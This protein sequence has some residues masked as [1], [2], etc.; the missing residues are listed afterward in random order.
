MSERYDIAI[1]G[2]GVVG[3]ALALL[4]VK[5]AGIAAASVLLIER[6][7]PRA[8]G[9]GAAFD[10]RVSAISP[11]NQA[12]LE[13]VGAW[14]RLD[15]ARIAAYE[16]MV[17]WHEAIPADSPDALIFDAA[18]MGEARLGV[19][20]ENRALQAALF[21]TCEAMGIVTR[22]DE[23]AA[24]QFDVDGVTLELGKH[25]VRVE[26]LV[27]A[28]G[29]QSRVR[30]AAGIAARV[31]S[32]SQQGIVATVQGAR[33]HRDTAWQCFLN[34]GPLAL[35]PLPG[36]QCS[37]VWSAVESEAA[38]LMSLPA[39]A[40]G[41]AVTAASDG[42]LG[43]LVLRSERAAFPLRRLTASAYTA[44][45]CVLV[46]DAAHVIHPLAGQGVN[47]GLQDAAA[48]A[49]ALAQRPRGESVAA[50]QALRRY[51]RARRSGNAVMA[52]T[53]DGFDKVFTGGSGFTAWAAR[54][55]MALV[56]RSAAA[57]RFFFTQAAAG[58]SSLRR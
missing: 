30:E 37:I 43:D 48:L 10:L 24:A 22:S 34:T 23:L 13:S 49:Q 56:N 27:G 8:P 14:Q 17:V 40:F 47:Q 50:Q 35:L 9:T 46:G 1:V 7:R 38:R 57:K 3:A 2:G 21:E 4:L 32:Y 39:D 12:L 36:G 42:V 5:E 29:A 20:V 11:A 55:G 45:R 54:E 51:E 33:G 6:D 53:V 16:R 28:D 52:A 26:L 41:A 44:A 15:P 19:I 25:S 31:D 18:E 58:R